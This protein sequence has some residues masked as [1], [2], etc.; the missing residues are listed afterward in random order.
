MEIALAVLAV[1]A[2]LLPVLIKNWS[3]KTEEHDDLTRHSVDELHAGTERV[4]PIQ[5]TKPP[6][7]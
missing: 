5:D 6:V 1:L 3:K 4:R 2:A 7:Q